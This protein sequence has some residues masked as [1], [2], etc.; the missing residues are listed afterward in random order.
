MLS[1]HA[2]ICPLATVGSPTIHFETIVDDIDSATQPKPG[3]SMLKITLRPSRELAIVPRRLKWLRYSF[4]ARSSGMLAPRRYYT[5]AQRLTQRAR[6]AVLLIILGATSGC[7]GTFANLMHV[8]QGNVVPPAFTGLKGK[9]VAVVCVSPS[10]AFGPAEATMVISRHVGKLISANVKDVQ[11]VQPRE[12][13]RWIDENDWDYLDYKMVGRGV[14]ADLVVAIDLSSFSLHE[15]KTL[16]KGRADVQ[17][18]VYD[19]TE[20]G[21]EVFAYQPSQIQYPENTGHHTTDMNEEAFRR[22]FLGIVA[23]RIA[24]QFY[25]YDTKED[26]ARDASVIRTS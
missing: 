17:V 22:Q 12:I 11:V 18:K 3:L 26:F 5:S 2:V 9:R 20:G 25:P 16:Y 21:E 24:R 8:A 4:P 15:G 13:E 1:N 23:S 14:K 6:L 19:L 10:D 7:I